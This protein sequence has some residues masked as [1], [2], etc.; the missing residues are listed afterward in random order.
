M[1]RILLFVLM[2]GSLTGCDNHLFTQFFRNP[3][4][5]E[6]ANVEVMEPNKWYEFKAKIKALNRSQSI[7]IEFNGSEPENMNMFIR[8]PNDIFKNGESVFTSVFFPGKEIFFDVLIVDL[9]NVEYEL[10][11]SGSSNGIIFHP[12]TE[13]SLIGKTFNK[14]KV[15]GNLKH[16]NIYITWISSTGK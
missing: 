13:K 2:V 16:K 7:L 4:I 6:V 12:K 11:A 8:P 10:E 1:K 15:K 9:D 3:Y 5:V 14:V